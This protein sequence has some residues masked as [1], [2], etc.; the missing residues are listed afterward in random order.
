MIT[1]ELKSRVDRLWTTFW[2]NGVSNPLSVIEQLSYLI[3]MRRLDDEELAAER[4]ARRFGGS[5]HV[6][7]GPETQS[8][9]WS[10]ISTVSDPEEQLRRARL[11]FEHVRALPGLEAT[12]YAEHMKDAVFLIANGPLMASAI[13][14][15]NEVFD[16][17]RREEEAAASAPTLPQGDAD[18]SAAGAMRKDLKGDLYEYMLS[19]LAQAGTNGQFRTPRHIIEMMVEML[20]PRLGDRICDPACGTAGFLVMAARYLERVYAHELAI[21]PGARAGFAR[22]TFHGYDF[23]GTM[24]RIASMNLLLHGVT[25]PDVVRADSLSTDRGDVRERFNVIL[26]NPP[27]K[28]SVDMDLVAE[29]LLRALEL[30]GAKKAKKPARSKLPAVEADDGLGEAKKTPGAKTELLFL[31]QILGALEVGGR[32]AVI[33]PDGVLF[34]SSKAHVAIRR[35]LVEHHLLDGV[36]SMPAGVF[37]PYAG[38]ST[39][40]LLFTKSGHGGTENVW[41]YD[42]ASDGYSLDDKRQ[43]VSANDIPDVIEKWRLRDDR[44]PTDRA[45]KAFFVPK[46]EIVGHGYDLSINRYKAVKA[47]EV[48]HRA[49]RVI[50]EELLALEGE[51]RAGLEKLMGVVG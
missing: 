10:V 47:I 7:F 22:G 25:H 15:V 19:K 1:G 42:M 40:I 27:F 46:S 17:I 5:P 29:D 16:A 49:P 34:G 12:P 4:K 26:A 30:E 36:V 24:L 13:R 45:A 21:E 33:V 14:Q 39:A 23:D 48:K 43:P 35:T 3:F 37:K 20:K 41:F 32:A 50:L 28:G 51:I 2:N 44:T 31:A 11:A 8:L 6:W 18:A 9:R 38:V